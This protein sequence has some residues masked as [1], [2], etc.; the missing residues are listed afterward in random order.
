MGKVTIVGHMGGTSSRG[1]AQA[2]L[3]ILLVPIESI[4]SVI[5][6]LKARTKW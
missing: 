6:H 1:I 2:S 5:L 3:N 4:I